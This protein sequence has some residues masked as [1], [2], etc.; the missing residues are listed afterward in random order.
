MEAHP[1]HVHAQLL[2][3]LEQAA[4][5]LDPRAELVGQRALR[6]RVVRLHA[7]HEIS[8]WMQTLQLDQLGFV[9]EDH[10]PDAGRLREEHGGLLLARVCVDRL[11][12]EVGAEGGHHCKLRGARK[13]KAPDAPV[14]PDLPE[15]ADEPGVA[16][17]LDCVEGLHPWQV[18]PPDL[19]TALH[20]ANIEKRQ[21]QVLRRAV[22]LCEEAL[23]RLNGRLRGLRDLQHRHPCRSPPPLG[24][25]RWGLRH[26]PKRC[27]GRRRPGKAA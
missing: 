5:V 26:R 6:Q 9:V 24:R 13:V 22:V 18:L 3:L 8:A 23:C 14:L 4:A 7:Q 16:V 10:Q 27:A 17:A 20:C 11:L 2:C 25:H 12:A 15:R 1:N 21:G 19:R